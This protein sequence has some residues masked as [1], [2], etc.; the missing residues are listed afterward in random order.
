MLADLNQSCAT[1]HDRHIFCNTTGRFYGSYP[2]LKI[3]MNDRPLMVSSY[4]Y[5]HFVRCAVLIFQG[6]LNGVLVAFIDILPSKNSSYIVVGTNVLM[7]YYTVFD[8]ENL[9]IGIVR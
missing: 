1:T 5:V 4:D 7:T 8:C 6:K 2:D 3:T 9:R